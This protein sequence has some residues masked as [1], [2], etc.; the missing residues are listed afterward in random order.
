MFDIFIL[1]WNVQILKNRVAMFCLFLK[2]VLLIMYYA[3]LLHFT[4][5]NSWKLLITEA[6]T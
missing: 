6:K 3:D 2:I 4:L 1:V 5:K